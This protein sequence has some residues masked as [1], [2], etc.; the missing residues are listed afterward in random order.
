MK[1]EHAEEAI[2]GTTTTVNLENVNF[3]CTE[4]VMA[5]ATILFRSS[6]ASKNIQMEHQNKVKKIRL[7]TVGSTLYFLELSFVDTV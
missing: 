4:V 7:I 6:L 3:L 2:P 5:T 1:R